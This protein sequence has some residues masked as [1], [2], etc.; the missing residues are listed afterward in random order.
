[1]KKSF[2]YY[3]MLSLL[4]ISFGMAK[5]DNTLELKSFSVLIP[6]GWRAEQT[7]ANS[8]TLILNE[9]SNEEVSIT[10]SCSPMRSNATLDNAWS[11]IKSVVIDKKAIISEDEDVFFNAKWKKIVVQQWICGK[12]VRKIIYFSIKDGNKWLIQFDS[13]KNTQKSNLEIFNRVKESLK[14]K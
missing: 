11:R 8:V 5:S 3:F 7:D 14:A 12:D 13:P 2:A 6:G 9:A 1:M 10:I 4:F